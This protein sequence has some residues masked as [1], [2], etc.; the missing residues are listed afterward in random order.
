MI[1]VAEKLNIEV[2][3]QQEVN[4]PECQ[5]SSNSESTGC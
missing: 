5:S 3:L 4:I 1:I 2:V